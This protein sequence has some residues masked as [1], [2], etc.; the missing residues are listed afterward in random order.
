VVEAL[1]LGLGLVAARAFGGTGSE[2]QAES[3]REVAINRLPATATG[4][5]GA[6]RKG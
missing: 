1:G 2:E 5:R 6:E 3:T 4:R